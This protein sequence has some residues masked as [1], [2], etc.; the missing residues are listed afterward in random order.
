VLG[1][2]LW[3]VHLGSW[4]YG[5][6][7]VDAAIGL[8]LAVAVLGGIGGQR[9]KRA[10]KLA[11]RLASEG[12]PASPELRALLDDRAALAVNYLSALLLLVIIVLM[13]FKPGAPH[14]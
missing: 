13:A 12:A 6:G 11:R 10:R 5:A 4:G 3:L 7:W 2:G 9:P 8:L 1:F 14:S